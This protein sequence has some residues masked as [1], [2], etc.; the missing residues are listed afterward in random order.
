MACLKFRGL[1]QRQLFQMD[2]ASLAHLLTSTWIL[3]SPPWPQ[4]PHHG[5]FV[6]PPDIY[7]DQG[8]PDP[9]AKIAERSRPQAAGDEACQGQPWPG[10]LLGEQRAPSLDCRLF[11]QPSLFPACWRFDPNPRPSSTR[12]LLSCV[13]GLQGCTLCPIWTKRPPAWSRGT[14]PPSWALD[15]VATQLRLPN[16]QSRKPA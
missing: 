14:L 2:D 4:S 10:S 16:L 3:H 9:Q 13:V 8:L 7:T 12:F 11:S 5:S 6:D 1:L 15:H